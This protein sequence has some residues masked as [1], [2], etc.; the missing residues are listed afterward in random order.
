MQIT[1]ILGQIGG[2]QSI[3]RELGVSESQAA[4]GADAL[5]PA[6]SADSRS[7]RRRS[8]RASMD[9]AACSSREPVDSAA[10]SGACSAAAKPPAQAARRRAPGYRDSP[11]CSI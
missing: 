11:R 4:N 1:D 7:R 9:S 3:A 10:C 5:L 2:L 8:L 6:S